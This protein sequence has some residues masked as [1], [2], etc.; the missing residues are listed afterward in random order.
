MNHNIH[1]AFKR[2]DNYTPELTPRQ[3]KNYVC[4]YENNFIHI[5]IS[6]RHFRSHHTKKKNA[7][8]IKKLQTI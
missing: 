8:I 2:L 4:V 6:A 5:I 3:T 1:L 7:I